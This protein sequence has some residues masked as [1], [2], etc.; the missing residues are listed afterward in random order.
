MVKCVSL[1][2]LIRTISVVVSGQAGSAKCMTV[3]IAVFALLHN[4]SMG[5]YPL[6]ANM[7]L[8]VIMAA[9]TGYEK[10]PWATIHICI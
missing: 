6:M 8:R 3:Y 1:L 7:G 4:S 10:C 5:V 2:M 9:V